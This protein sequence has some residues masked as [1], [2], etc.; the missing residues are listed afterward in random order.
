MVIMVLGMY[1]AIKG[2]AD[3]VSGYRFM[4]QLRIYILHSTLPESIV[5]LSTVEP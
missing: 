2:I 1:S 5:I 4:A 3:N